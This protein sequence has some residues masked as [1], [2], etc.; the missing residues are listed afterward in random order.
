MTNCFDCDTG[1]VERRKI[2]VLK[3]LR[4]VSLN[5]PALVDVCDNCG[6]WEV[7]LEHADTFG[8]ALDSAYRSRTGLLSSLQ[9]REARERLKMSQRQFAEYIGVGEASVKRWE[10]GAL[11]DKS[12]DEVIRLKTDPEYARRSL[13]KLEA[14]VGAGP[15]ETARHSVFLPA[16]PPVPPWLSIDIAAV[17]PLRARRRAGRVCKN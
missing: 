16:T 10:L 15:R 11:Q 14:R 1:R 9:I 2:H 4:G 12:S 3:E 8:A 17:G 7:P 5:F 6:V 13:E